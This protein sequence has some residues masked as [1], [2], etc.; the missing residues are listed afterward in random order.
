M[1]NGQ[2]LALFL[3]LV[4]VV[5]LIADALD[6]PTPFGPAEHRNVE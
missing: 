4:M 5:F 1:S 6:W 3:A 2:R